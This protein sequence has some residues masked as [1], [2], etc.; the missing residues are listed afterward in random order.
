MVLQAYMLITYFRTANR[1]FQVIVDYLIIY[2]WK[3][4]NVMTGL[5][6]DDDVSKSLNVIFLDDIQSP[7]FA[8]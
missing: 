6:F 4:P 7:I 5:L 3:K 2:E 8:K 1:E